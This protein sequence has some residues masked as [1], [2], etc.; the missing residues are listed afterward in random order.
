MVGRIVE[1]KIA[2]EIWG[3]LNR[4]YQSPSIATVIGLNSQLQKI[5]KEGITISEYLARIKKVFDKYSAMGEPLSYKDK[6]MHTLNGLTEK[7]DGFVTSIYNRSDKPYL[8]EVHSLLYTYEYRLEQ[9]NTAQ[10]LQLPQSFRPNS[11]PSILGKPQGQ[12]QSSSKWFQ[13]QGTRNFRPRTQCQICGKFS[14]IALNC[15]HRPQPPNP[16]AAMLTTSTSPTMPSNNCDTPCPMKLIHLKHVLHTPQISKQL[17]ISG[18]TSCG[19]LEDGL[20]KVSSSSRF[21]HPCCLLFIAF[22]FTLLNY[23][24]ISHRLPFVLS[25]SKA[26]KPFDLVHSDLWGPFPVLSVTESTLHRPPPPTSHQ[27]S[28]HAYFFSPSSQNDHWQRAMTTEYEAL[29]RN[30]TWT[31]MPLL[32]DHKVIGCKWVFKVKLKPDGSLERYKARLVAKAL[33]LQWPI[34]QLDVHNAFLNG[35]LSEIVFMEQPPGFISATNPVFFSNK[36]SSIIVL[37]IYADD[38]IITGSHSAL[39]A[40]K[41]LG[42]LSYF[43][44]IQVTCTPSY[45]HLCQHKYIVDLLHQAQMFDCKHA[46]TPMSTSSSL[47]LYDGEPLLDPSLNHNIVGALQYC[48]ITRPDISFSVNNVCQFM[49]SP[50]TTHWQAVKRILRYLKSTIYHGI[51]LQPSTTSLTCL[52][53]LIGWLPDDRKSTSGHYCFLGPNL[54][55]W[56]Y[57]KQKV[58]SRSSAESEYKGLVNAALELI[59]IETFLNELH[60]LFF[61]PPVLFCDN[62]TATHLATHPIFHART[63]HIE[64]D[65]H[66]IHDRVLHKSLLV[67][68]TH[69]EKQIADILTKPLSAPRFQSLRNKLT[70][71]H[72]PLSLRGDDK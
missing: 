64:I 37:L 21:R 43:L 55:S 70:V 44:G 42:Y 67:K 23:S 71:L 8:E 59:W 56:S 51:S 32:P 41:D 24:L 63:K 45:L 25:E 7:Y 27:H 49:H 68:F 72:S 35:D 15:Y 58:V 48:T 65:Y 47:S 11:Q 13:K 33:S 2:C 5:K 34:K 14:H 20:Y 36:G 4:V 39:F 3:A 17:I 30:Y 26:M 28:F 40:F 52:S 18:G 50:T 46:S 57:T 38:I 19:I 9:R 54:I 53:M 16:I 12:P 10:Q 61:T 29:I 6:L 69:S 66:F 62:L 60:I 1:Y 22:T 31:L